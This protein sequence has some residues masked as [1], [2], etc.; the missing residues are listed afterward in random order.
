MILF[1]LLT[2]LAAAMLLP[3]CGSGVGPAYQANANGVKF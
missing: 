2:V 1:Y 3:R